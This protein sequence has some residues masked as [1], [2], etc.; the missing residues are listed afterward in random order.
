MRLAAATGTYICFEDEA[1]QN[2]RPPKARTWAP[3]GH[4]PVTVVSGKGSGRVSVAGLTC[5]RPGER[6][7]LFYRVRVHRGRKGERRSMSEAD[8]ASL[9]TAAHQRLSAPVILIWDNLN[10]HISAVMRRFIEAHPEW[11]TEV[12]LPAYAPHLNPVEGAWANMKNS[13]GNRA[14]RN[15][16]QLT[17]IVKNQ[18]A[19]ESDQG[20]TPAFLSRQITPVRTALATHH[21]QR[22][23]HPRSACSRWLSAGV[24]Q[25]CRWSR[26]S[27]GAGWSGGCCL[28]VRRVAD[29]FPTGCWPRGSAGRWWRR[30]RRGLAVTDD[31]FRPRPS[32]GQILSERGDAGRG[33]ADGG[34]GEG[35][36]SMGRAVVHFEIIGKDNATLHPFYSE[37]FGWKLD[38]NNP[39]NYGVVDRSENLN[40]DGI[41]IGG[42]VGA[43]TDYPGHVTVYVEVPD[44]EEALTRAEALGGKRLMG[45]EKLMEGVEIGMFND[46]EGH[47]I[48][49]I[50]ATS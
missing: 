7:R 16:D 46:P 36:V 17:A 32:S 25:F 15:V 21:Q 12:R 42:G 39:M 31:G 5:Y 23:H 33:P 2:L 28:V 27:W 22:S 35:M 48:G 9:I 41:G 47:R 43:M 18:L 10:T 30:R 14:A 24:R 40:A 20:R 26:S 29:G 49:V 38:A 3:R 1:G 6:S 45:P 50:K 4:I 44:V 37:M 11:L 8:Y 19:D 34:P 13:L